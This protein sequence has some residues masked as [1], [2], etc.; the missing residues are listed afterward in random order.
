MVKIVCLG[1]EFV[2]EDSLA[3]EVGVLLS[4]EYEVVNLKDS[5]ELMGIVSGKD[6]FVILDV[7]EGLSEVLRLR[8][9]DLRGNSFVSA[10]D[11]DAGYVLKLLD[12]EVKIIGIPIKGDA[13]V[14]AGEVREMIARGFRG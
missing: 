12:V 9:D 14:I 3:V 7:V 13:G 4:E 6:D 11:L 5:F 2:E 10:H 8:V 1:N